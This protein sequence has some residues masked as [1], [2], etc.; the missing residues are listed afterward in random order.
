M[1]VPVQARA[2]IFGTIAVGASAL[3]YSVVKSGS[4]PLTTLALLGAAVVLTEVIQVAGDD[5][6]FDPLEAH[7]FSFSSGV[8][9]A[10]V[11]ILGPWAAALVAAFGVLVVDGSR[12]TEYRRVAYNAS[13]LALAA[14]AGGHMY[15]L[16][17][18]DPG[19]LALP[20]GFGPILGL[21]V[22]YYAVN[23][24]LVS[25]VIA[26]DA[27]TSLFALGAAAIRQA[28]SSAAGEV[29]FGFAL[30]FFALTEPWATVALVPLVLA[31][32][33]SHERLVTLRRETA[34]ALESFANVVDERD[35]YTFRHSDRVAEYVHELAQALDL[36]SSDVTRLRWAGRLHDLGKITVD[37]AV[38]RKPGQ[39]DA[40]EWE[41]MRRHPR[42]SA[43]LLR[44]FRFAVQEARAVEYHHERFDGAGYYG[45]DTKDVPLA[46]HFLIVADSFDAMT[47][48]RPYRNGLSEEVALAEIEKNSGSQFHPTVA[49][50]FVALRR[51]QDVRAALTAAEVAEFRHLGVRARVL[52]RK[53]AVRWEHVAASA[54]VVALGSF[55]AGIAVLALPAI[56]LAVAAVALQRLTE[57]RAR[58]LAG[59]LR[60]VLKASLTREESFRGLISELSL[61]CRLRWAG[62][63][64]WRVREGAGEIDLEWSAGANRPGLTSITSW[65]VREAEAATDILLAAGAELG[66]EDTHVAV[67]LLRDGSPEG[68]LVL[69]IAG[70]VPAQLEKALR[71]SIDAIGQDLLQLNEQ[72]ARLKAVA[73]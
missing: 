18:G 6:S 14:V 17:G 38:L 47:S 72:P 55:A 32:Y 52:G 21:A 29:G 11:V 51:G 66:R 42:L 62:V 2:L 36:P 7:A 69:A 35:S 34:R 49:K 27:G 39:L 64:A 67:P 70:H 19:T 68:Y 28:L 71:L 44:R 33:R 53:I 50:A 60:V 57:I 4:A 24:F 12:S 46:A 22:V 26:L 43:R 13:V 54:V 9:I 8:H 61:E 59:R 5:T 31:V 56:A 15:M 48:D 65:L 41:T 40:E 10:S 16:L 58:K 30:A 23:A 63:L 25:L 37:A 73:V 3:I 1:R 45:V 20:D